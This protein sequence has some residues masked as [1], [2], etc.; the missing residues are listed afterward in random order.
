MFPSF[1][2]PT[3]KTCYMISGLG[4][5]PFFGSRMDCCS[6]VGRVSF[7]KPGDRIWS[8]GPPRRNQKYFNYLRHRES[9]TCGGCRDTMH[10]RSFLPPANKLTRGWRTAR[11]KVAILVLGWLAVAPGARAEPAE[12]ALRPAAATTMQ[13]VTP[14]APKRTRRYWK[15]FSTGRAPRMGPTFPGEH[16]NPTIQSTTEIGRENNPRRIR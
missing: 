8:I 15:S 3:V 4:L 2:S 14:R 6:E 1:G 5:K 11:L 9:E 16:R 10:V 13:R 7:G 12:L